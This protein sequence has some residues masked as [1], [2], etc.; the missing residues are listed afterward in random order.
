[1]VNLH[2]SKHKN[3]NCLGFL[4]KH[5]RISEYD[6]LSYKGVENARQLRHFLLCSRPRNCSMLSKNA[7]EVGKKKSSKKVEHVLLF[8]PFQ[9]FSSLK[10]RFLISYG[11]FVRKPDTFCSSF[12][13]FAKVQVYRYVYH[14]STY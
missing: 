1:M 11:V 3:I 4:Q 14:H 9:L 5:H 7:T 12:C 2:F 10:H 8:L 13:Y 6:V